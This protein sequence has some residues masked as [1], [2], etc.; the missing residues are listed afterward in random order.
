MTLRMKRD[1][2]QP[3]QDAPDPGSSA[4]GGPGAT[5]RAAQR[6]PL[7]HNSMFVMGPH[8]NA[9]WLHGINHDNRPLRTKSEEEQVE[10]GARISLTFR[11]I[12]TFLSRDE[13]RIWGQGASAKNKEDAGEVVHG[14]S[15]AS[16]MI[17]AFGEENQRSDFDWDEV[18]GNGFDVLHFKV[19]TE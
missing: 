11:H 19:P 14:G 13:K 3:S 4:A 12:G 2:M 5:P 17:S 1:G 15:A 18:Y 6:I 16:R 8:T 9:R 7:P 10:G